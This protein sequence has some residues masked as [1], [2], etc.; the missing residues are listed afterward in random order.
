VD[1]AALVEDLRNEG[2][3]EVSINRCLSVLRGAHRRAGAR[4]GC[5]SHLIDW[6]DL[7]TREAK[8]RV[9]WATREEAVA[10][11]GHCPDHIALIV[12]WSLYTGLRKRETLSLMRTDFDPARGSVEVIVKGG[13]K[14]I[15]QLSQAALDVLAR[16]P[17]LASGRMFD[18]T[19]LRKHFIAACAKAGL[20]DF[21]FH[22]LRH[23]FATWL[24]QGGA[25]LEV[26]SRA[27]GHSSIHVTQKYAHV[28]DKEVRQATAGI[29]VLRPSN[30]VHLRSV[31]QGRKS[32]HAGRNQKG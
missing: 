23:T 31:R 27:L 32:Q 5:P 12:E 16:A 8:E 21:H 3:G 28:D 10:L 11:V 7:R 14:R 26:V 19:N 29:G 6:R 15:V 20:K 30:L 25:P 18:R 1:C 2:M 24:R 4:W 17:I 13:S 9:V 22:D